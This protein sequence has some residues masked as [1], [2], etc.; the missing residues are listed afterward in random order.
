MASTDPPPP[1]A[2]AAAPAHEPLE[3]DV[4]SVR[5]LDKVWLT[6]PGHGKLRD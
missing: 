2:A 3:A 4:S 6:R 1:A 5:C